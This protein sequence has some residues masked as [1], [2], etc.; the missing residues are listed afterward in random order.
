[1]NS[2]K[3]SS[4]SDGTNETNKQYVFLIGAQKAGTTTLAEL[5]AQHDEI[6]LSHPKEPHFFSFGMNKGIDWYKSLFSDMGATL[7]LDASTSYTMMPLFDQEGEEATNKVPQ[8]I[9]EFSQNPRFIYVVRNHADRVHSAYWHN[10][11]AGEEPLNFREA[12]RQKNEYFAPT[13]YCRQLDLYFDQF[14]RDRF[15]ILSFDDLISNPV[16]TATKCLEFLGTRTDDAVTFTS[17]KNQSFQYTAIGSVVRR[18]V[19]SRQRMKMI[20]RL[21]KK[22]LP[23]RAWQYVKRLASRPIPE[24]SAQD[25]Q[26]LDDRFAADHARLTKE[27]GIRLR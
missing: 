23:E 27:F 20:T 10:V 8:R 21:L 2:D 7:C 9:R 25:R 15:L 3:K 5:L 12:L 6:C 13:E 16:A 1:M 17:P 4:R 24:L 26:W 22:F 14:P 18:L 19:G 11:R